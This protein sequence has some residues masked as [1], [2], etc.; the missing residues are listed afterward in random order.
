MLFSGL[1]PGSQLGW[2]LRTGIQVWVWWVSVLLGFFC[3]WGVCVCVCLLFVVFHEPEQVLEEKEM[4][5]VLLSVIA[6]E[7]SVPLR[8][9]IKQV[10]FPLQGL[11]SPVSPC[12]SLT[13]NL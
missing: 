4:L 8:S 7:Q 12:D 10:Q 5:S 13:A 6:E 11:R 2:L 3:V 9:Q 1:H